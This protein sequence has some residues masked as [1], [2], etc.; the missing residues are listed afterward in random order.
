MD[1]YNKQNFEQLTAEFAH[2]VKNPV[3]LIKANIEYMQTSDTSGLYEKNYG[4]IK[5]ELQKINNVV[6]EF[7]KL[8]KPISNSEKEIIFIYDL[9]SEVIEEFNTPY[10]GK[11]IKFELICSDE[12]IKIFGEYSKICIVFFNIY[13]NAVEAI[14][15]KGIIKTSI[16]KENSEITIKIIDNGIGIAA[17][18][19][20]EIGTP[21][22]T[23]KVG[24]S[25]LGISICKKII[26]E[27]NGTFNIFNNIKQGC[28]VEIMLTACNKT[29]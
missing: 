26:E 5:K 20:E 19:E 9:I 21:F 24:G 17:E 10:E 1:F 14:K 2:E 3:S 25:G 8:T 4:I 6:M 27:H 15:D 12:D 18:L 29:E 13:K 28:T 23:T 22:F 11:D 7:I 16:S